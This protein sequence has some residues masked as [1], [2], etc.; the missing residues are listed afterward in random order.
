MTYRGRV[1]NGIVVLDG[2]PPIE[3]GTLVD[4][5]PIV[6]QETPRRGSAQ[7]IMRHAG[8][9]EPVAEEVDE[10]LEIL[11][12]IKQEELRRQMDRDQ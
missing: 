6:P 10:Q 4:V 5:V 8:I 1:K 3:E 12:Q 11:K 9:W 7:A 2:S